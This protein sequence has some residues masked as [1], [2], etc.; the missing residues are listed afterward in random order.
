MKTKEFS[1]GTCLE[2]SIDLVKKKTNNFRV[3]PVLSET[4]LTP[5]VKDIALA[6]S[7]PLT[8]SPLAIGHFETFLRT[9]H[10]W[11]LPIIVDMLFPFQRKTILWT[12]KFEFSFSTMITAWTVDCP[13]REASPLKL[14]NTSVRIFKSHHNT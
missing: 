8:H 7:P 12:L 2:R 11:L 13:F 6:H 3:Y 5:A 14:Y 4:C 9:N 1:T 10:A